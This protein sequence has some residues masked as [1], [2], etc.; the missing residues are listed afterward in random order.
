MVR[1][2]DFFFVARKREM[3]R[4]VVRDFQRLGDVLRQV[5]FL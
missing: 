4:Q 5:K 1:L 2:Q 3:I